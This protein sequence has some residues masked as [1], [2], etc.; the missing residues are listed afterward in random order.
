[1]HPVSQASSMPQ[2][3]IAIPLEAMFGIQLGP[4]PQRTS[5]VIIEEDFEE[6]KSD[7]EEIEIELEVDQELEKLEKEV[8]RSLSKRKSKSR[9]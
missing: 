8:E 2:P 5:S 1:M 7:S 6:D 4:P 3:A 9:K